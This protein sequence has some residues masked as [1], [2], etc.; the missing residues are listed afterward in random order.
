MCVCAPALSFQP[1]G[2]VAIEEAI[3][4]RG[5]FLTLAGCFY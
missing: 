4:K 5:C 2:P 1:A 3:I